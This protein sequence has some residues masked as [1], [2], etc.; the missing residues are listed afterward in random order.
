VP[1]TTFW[2]AVGERAYGGWAAVD[3]DGL[4]ATR[5]SVDRPW[6]I[7]RL[8]THARNDQGHAVSRYCEALNRLFHAIRD[9]SGADVVVD[10]S[11]IASH[12]LLLRRSRHI[13]VR[14]V[15][16]VRDS[17]GVAYSAQKRVENCTT[18][19]APTLLPQ[20]GP[21]SASIRYG[22]Y[23]GLADALS[24]IG[25]PHIRVRYED[26]VDDPAQHLSR[27]LGL[28][29][30]QTSSLDFLRG[31]VA[32]LR[33]N[34]IVDGNPIRFTTGRVTL[35]RDEDWTSAMPRGQRAL[36]TGLTFPL[37]SAYGY[38]SRKHNLPRETAG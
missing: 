27:I 30:A 34:H 22:L 12:A 20:H 6:G 18:M 15:H 32:A 5:Y 19:G 25:I 26:L 10:S 14:V 2:R 9:V 36:V 37:L 8:L 33:T 38:T 29:G 11:K 1:A 28:A 21:V 7:P 35:H 4:L 23:N 24:L 31:G 3:L 16:L 17:R 13:D